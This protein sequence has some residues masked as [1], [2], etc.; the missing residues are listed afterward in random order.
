M[1]EIEE[2]AAATAREAEIETGRATD[3]V[4][5]AWSLLRPLFPSMH[6]FLRELLTTRHPVQSSQVSIYLPFMD[7][8]SWISYATD[9]LLLQMIGI[10][11]QQ[12]SL[13]RQNVT[14]F[15]SISSLHQGHLSLRSYIGSPCEMF[16]L[17]LRLSRPLSSRYSNRLAELYP[18]HK[19]S[20]LANTLIL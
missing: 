5:Q 15:P 2:E 3:Q 4:E 9:I 17:M 18:H 19:I 13:C 7:T 16:S 6:D 11:A 1:K 8:P 12:G 10:S 20:L 14:L